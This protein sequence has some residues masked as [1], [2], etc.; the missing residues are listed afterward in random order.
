LRLSNLLITIPVY[1]KGAIAVRKDLSHKMINKDNISIRL[2]L[3]FTF[4]LIVAISLIWLLATTLLSRSLEQRLQAQLNHANTILAQ[5]AFPYTEPLLARLASLLDADIALIHADG[6]IGQSTVNK[7]NLALNRA[8]SEHFSS[9]SPASVSRLYIGN[10]TYL[11]AYYLF[12]AGNDLRYAAVASVASLNDAKQIATESAWWLGGG[13]VLGI[14][15]FALVGHRLSHSITRPIRKLAT[16]AS[17]IAAGDRSVKTPVH[18]NNEIG[19]LAEALN[20]MTAR[21][22]NYE[23]SVAEKSRYTALGQMAARVAH[24][25]RNPLTAIKMQAQLLHESLSPQQSLRSGAIIDEIKRLELIV[26]STLDIT[27]PV[28]LTLSPCDPNQLIG[29]FVSLLRPTLEHRDIQISTRLLNNPTIVALDGDRIKQVLL[30][31]LVN[32]EDELPHGGQI[33]ISSEY[34]TNQMA[35]LISV[36]DSGPGI[37]LDR[38]KSVFN[39][40]ESGKQTGFGLGLPICKELIELHNGQIKIQDSELGGAK[41]VITLPAEER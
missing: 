14:I 40:S 17:K 1:F 37:P 7:G 13:A 23:Q 6:S 39:Q 33:M 9:N 28:Q 25:I 24:E 29:E 34:V 36:E 2:A 12:N 27:K 15:L 18:E 21:L 3:P 5:G 26:A 10:D 30:N 22:A 8:I 19:E 11:A 4:L 32:A 20:S 16:M 31:L 41:F 35:L 38:R